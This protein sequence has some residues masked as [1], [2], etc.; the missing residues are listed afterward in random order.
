MLCR[1]AFVRTDVSEELSASFIRVTR[2]GE[3]GTT[4]AVTSNQRALRI[5]TV[6]SGPCQCSHP[7]V[8]IPLTTDH[9]LLFHFETPPTWGSGLCIYILRNTMVHLYLQAMDSLSI[10][11]QGYCG[12]ILTHLH[13][14]LTPRTR[15]SKFEVDSTTGGQLASFC[16]CQPPDQI[17]NSFLSDSYFK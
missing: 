7:R 3:L 4:V 11:S 14:G 17:P 2:I 6:V 12:G 16:W 9:I 8:Q 10:A 5:N 1:V 15:S 13:T